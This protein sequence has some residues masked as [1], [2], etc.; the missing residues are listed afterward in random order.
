MTKE[1]R[2]RSSLMVLGIVLLAWVVGHSVPAIAQQGTKAGAL[3][4]CTL[5]VAGMTCAGCEAAVR[6]A[7]KT[8]DGVKDVKASDDKKN[9]DVTDDPSKTTPEAIAK[10]ITERSGFRA[11]AQPEKRKQRAGLTEDDQMDQ[12][13]CACRMISFADVPRA[14]HH[15]AHP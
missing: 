9:A 8:V 2:M 15:E 11:T 14:H 3:R 13:G 12:L 10:V 5:N 4:V 6:S 1:Q 7:A